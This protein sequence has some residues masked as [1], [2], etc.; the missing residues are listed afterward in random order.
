[1]L[2]LC[3]LALVAT[4]PVDTLPRGAVRGV[5]QSEPSGLPVSAAVVEV[6]DGQTV[7]RSLSDSLGVYRLGGLTAGP[8]RVRVHH[9]E[10]EPMEAEVTVPR[11]AEVTLDVE[12][13]YR[14]LSLDTLRAESD[15][16][17]LG[18]DTTAA[19]RAD[20]A[21]AETRGVEGN[22]T[23]GTAMPLPGDPP[24][25]EDDDLVIRGSAADLRLVLLDGAPVYAPF[26]MGGL[27]DA[28]EPTVLG[29]AR[30]H[31]AGAPARFDGGLSY[32]MELA[33]RAGTPTHHVARGSL[34]M[35]AVR[36][37]AE[38]PLGGGASYMAAGRS[39]HGATLGRLE[40]DPFPYE[41][42]DGLARVDV[43]VGADGRVRLMAFGNREAVRMQPGGGGAEGFAWW[44]SSAAS[45]RFN[46]D[47]L[48]APAEGTI[49]VS[50]FD[51]SIPQRRTTP[52]EGGTRRVRTVM[53]LSQGRG[54]VRMRYGVSYDAI[55][56]HNELSLEVVGGKRQIQS[57]L[58]AQAAAVFGDAAWQVSPRLLLRG[59]ARVDVF[60]ED[61]AVT[62][63]P[64]IAATWL[65]GDQAA[66]TIAAGRFHQYL[67]GRSTSTELGPNSSLEDSVRNALSGVMRVAG[68]NHISV[69]LD[70]QTTE[71]V[72]LGVEGFYKRF[73]RVP[74]TPG[75]T[76]HNSGFDV[77]ARRSAG[78]IAGWLGYTLAWTWSEE[79]LTT[80]SDFQGRHVLSAG[81]NGS[82]GRRGRFS[83]RLQF[84]SPIDNSRSSSDPNSPGL[85]DAE[86]A[87][88]L[89]EGEGGDL[90]ADAPV[91]GSTSRY[92]Y[93]RLDAQVSRTWAPRLAGRRTE[94]TPYLRVINALDRRDPLF[95]RYGNGNA[96]EPAA[97]LPLL[98]VFGIDWKF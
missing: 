81:A 11:G 95:Y 27:L 97:T 38:G 82:L 83:L 17:G 46:G 76:T 70:Q 5:V 28:F 32:V 64:R 34:D 35:V 41:F 65:V 98:P 26:H 84:G 93:V 44:R 56:I 16:N 74:E 57:D 19:Q 13:R 22:P 77:W 61:V 67:R 47:V 9:L 54:P 14:P 29:A 49:A 4:A 15:P 43:P 90:E 69:S 75:V 52:L 55:R 60:S 72:R 92:E 30:L 42:R 85:P 58:Y 50:D 79:P 23:T 59:G 51:A 68:A 87:V 66:L 37:V 2:A 94:L 8:H 89:A 48:G 18:A 91:L 3:L 53:E 6:S 63:S 1:V 21:R 24:P 31:L 62:A 45:L 10:H 39:V 86:P 88:G 40:G 71:G 96:I 36:A 12:L 73:S 20:I 78:P 80:A 33:T 7:L 25:G